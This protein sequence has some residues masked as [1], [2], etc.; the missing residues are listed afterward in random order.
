MHT[1]LKSVEEGHGHESGISTPRAGR[2][3]GHAAGVAMLC[4]SFLAAA[5]LTPAAPARLGAAESSH[6]RATPW[7]HG[8]PA[9][10]PP[11]E[12]SR[13][14]AAA[15]LACAAATQRHEHDSRAPAGGELPPARGKQS[16]PAP[17]PITV[18]FRVYDFGHVP[19]RPA[20]ERT[21]HPVPAGL[22]VLLGQRRRPPAPSAAG[23]TWRR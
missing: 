12:G 6:M 9:P 5:W 2:G 19:S 16:C 14:A 22:P 3:L 10:P 13:A 11:C 23:G 15:A 21:R 7:G 1:V 18:M 4:G 20:Q 8:T 17:N